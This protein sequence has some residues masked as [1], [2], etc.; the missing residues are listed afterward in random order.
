MEADENLID[1]Q[2]VANCEFEKPPK[3]NT[4]VGLTYDH[5]TAVQ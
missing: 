2:A 5:F 3:S 4:E 1:L